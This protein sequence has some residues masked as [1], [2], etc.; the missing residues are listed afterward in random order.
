MSHWKPKATSK[1]QSSEG[2][3]G[4]YVLSREVVT[5]ASDRLQVDAKRRVAT[6]GDN[7]KAQMDAVV[8]SK[9][10]AASRTK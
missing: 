10:H 2:L 9:R 3:P 8:T 1:W 6:F 5:Q 4:V 7:L